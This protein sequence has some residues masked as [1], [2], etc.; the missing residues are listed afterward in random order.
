MRVEKFHSQNKCFIKAA[1]LVVCRWN[2]RHRITETESEKIEI[3][4]STH[5]HSPRAPSAQRIARPPLIS[6]KSHWKN[7]YAPQTISS[8]NFLLH[9]IEREVLFSNVKT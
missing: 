9:S 4:R 8:R 3:K 6:S 5:S 1:G 2:R 7:F